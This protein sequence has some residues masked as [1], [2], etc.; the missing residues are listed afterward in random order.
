MHDF[1]LFKNAVAKQFERMRGHDLFCVGV[2]RD[3]LWDCYLESFPQGSNPTYR[4][5]R[6]HDCSCCRQFIRTM[7][8]VVAVI[9]GHVE[10]IWDNVDVGNGAYDIVSGEMAALVASRPIRDVFVHYEQYV[11]TDRNFETKDGLNVATWNHFSAQLPER[12]NEG[13]ACVVAKAS[14]ATIQGD[15]KS[16]RDVFLRSLTEITS[17]AVEAVSEI[18]D[19]GA[20]YRGNEYKNVVAKFATA[21]AQ[22]NGLTTGTDRA[23]FAWVN[24]DKVHASVA[25]IKNT[26]IG[27]LLED[28]SSGTEL[29]GAVK[30]FETTIVAPANFKRSTALV[31]KKM[32]DE[33]RAKVEALGLTEALERRRAVATDISA[34]DVLF[35]DR[36]ARDVMRDGDVFAG[37]DTK[38]THTQKRLAEAQSEM[39]IEDFIR[40]VLPTATG[41]EVMF[42]NR[43]G[44]NMVSLLAPA[45]AESKPLLKWDNGFSWA[46]RG[47]VTDSIKERVKKAGGN[48]TGDLCCRLAWHN[49]DDLDLHMKFT[50][51]IAG[52]SRRQV[53]TSTST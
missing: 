41:V 17:D 27:T 23:L 35:A 13:R 36:T 42:E 47:D 3:E 8:G 21:Q 25:R 16:L 50:T 44:G 31:S 6:E 34:R 24:F 22:F 1:N 28:L 14:M 2:G 29:E 5:R 11:G 33:A 39:K 9:D 7:G 48:V 26:A 4:V 18:I 30:R 51:P 10:T 53:V 37:V 20:L 43:H 52:A 15:A 32:V 49:H 45:H 46:Y 12:R 38:R 40:D 19:N